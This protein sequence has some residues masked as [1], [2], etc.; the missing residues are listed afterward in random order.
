MNLL[1]KQYSKSSLKQCKQCFHC[2][3]LYQMTFKIFEND[4]IMNNNNYYYGV[5]WHFFEVIQIWIIYIYIYIYISALEFEK[6][7]FLVLPQQLDGLLITFKP[8]T[9]RRSPWGV[10]LCFCVLH[11]LTLTKMN[12]KF[13]KLSCT[14][15]TFKLIGLPK[16]CHH[17]SS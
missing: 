1:N 15:Q 16:G 3:I 10:F 9:Q 6:N 12:F 11:P 14:F 8:N 17:D 7:Q 2:L 13:Q 5:M 4:I